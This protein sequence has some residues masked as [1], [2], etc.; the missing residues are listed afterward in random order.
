[1]ARLRSIPQLRRDG[2]RLVTI[3]STLLRFGF[4]QQL[5][6]L[7][8]E[9]IR[10]WLRHDV[11]TEHAGLSVGERLCGAF[12]ELGPTFVKL[13]QILSTRPDIV[14][15][16]VAQDLRRLQSDALTDS[17]GDVR[18]QIE[19]ELGGPI[20][21]LFQSFDATPMA[22]A[23]IAQVHAVTLKD[24]T[25]A[26]VKVQHP[27]IQERLRADLDALSTL[28]AVLDRCD[29][30]LSGF[31]LPL[32]VE[33]LRRS[34]MAELDF[35]QELRTMERFRRA[36]GGDPC[37]K[38]PKPIAGLSSRRVLTM[39]RVDG[40]SVALT[41]RLRSDGHDLEQ[42][43]LV[44]A[45]LFLEMVFSEGAFHAD[46]HPGNL[47]VDREG[48][49]VL[50]DFGM[51]GVIDHE[52]REQL[53][54]LIIALVKEDQDGVQAAVRQI[55]TVPGETDQG[56]LWRDLGSLQQEVTQKPIS[57]LCV[58]DLLEQFTGIL[59]RHRILL[60]PS[61]SML[62]KV[63]VMLEGTSRALD[64][65]FSLLRILTPYCE[66]LLRQRRA[67]RARA[68]RALRTGR[69]WARLGARLPKVLERLSLQIEEGS[70]PVHLEHKGLES[71]V[72]RLVSGVLC[73]AMLLGGSAMWGLRAPPVL[74]GAP[75]VGVL[76][77]TLGLVHGLRL[78]YQLGR[79]GPRVRG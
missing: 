68:R 22:S 75:V 57:E 38:I 77:T 31:Q 19:A 30:E 51:V 74:L 58:T 70:V 10:R 72:D 59:R 43:A 34:L 39:E 73:A 1:M 69:T 23:S 56:R 40:Y 66:D 62:I 79:G 9:F 41:D 44:G 14:P 6:Q 5:A 20:E 18:R 55:A 65:K 52:I 71:T 33:E 7:E 12:E 63:L 60:P 76:M 27:G 16:E 45:R 50:L 35:R 8:P 25:P 78:L 47:F 61:I 48:R 49:I 17:E 24:G 11:S 28:A 3:S 13:G 42:L 54:D 21:S 46:P 29:G 32:V 15:P 4:A 53:V 2:S 67:P 37:V 64:P 36:F 26:V